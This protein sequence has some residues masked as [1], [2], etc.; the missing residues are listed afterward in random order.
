MKFISAGWLR[1]T[2]RARRWGR[3]EEARSERSGATDAEAF[4]RVV[5][6]LK[7]LGA[8]V[9]ARSLTHSAALGRDRARRQAKCGGATMATAKGGGGRDGGA[10]D[11]GD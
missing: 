11:G 10:R 9:R 8:T 5:D 6:A 2:S 4:A 7:G 3:S 1:N